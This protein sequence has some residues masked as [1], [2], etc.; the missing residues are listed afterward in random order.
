MIKSL[1]TV[2]VLVFCLAF[3]PGVAQAASN[4]D[5]AHSD[6]ITWNLK[7]E[8]AM[9]AA[10]DSGRQVIA[11]FF[12]D[13]CKW[14]KVQD[15]STFTDARVIALGSRFYFVRIN[16]E[17]DT[18][19]AMKYGVNGYPTVI[20]F[21]KTGAEVDR[22]VG[23]LRPEEFIATIE[24]YLEGTGTK[25]ALE[26]K[27]RENP[28]DLGIRFQLVMKYEGRGDFDMA[29]V[30]IQ[31]IMISDPDNGSKVTDKAMFELAVMDRKEKN[32]YKSIE[33][34]RKFIKKFPGSKMRE[35]AETYIPWLYAKAGDKKQALKFYKAF[36]DEFS[37]S[38]QVGWVK[39]QIKLLEAPADSNAA[40]TSG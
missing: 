22:I 16:A 21:D 23:Y 12:T 2:A 24:D 28:Q 30:Q 38:S 6:S 7:L 9:K 33:S 36:L 35:D 27:S 17:V 8:A 13:W 20:L 11:D 14:C 32:W 25:A 10:A 15:E 40:K 29:R 1:S 3:L 18:T 31:Q 37:G 4:T 19:N 34:F 26:T 5:V 39:D